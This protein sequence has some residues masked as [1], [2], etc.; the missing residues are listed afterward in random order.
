MDVDTEVEA[1]AFLIW[2]LVDNK[3]EASFEYSHIRLWRTK[4]SQAEGLLHKEACSLAGVGDGVSVVG[5][6]GDVDDGAGGVD[7]TCVR[8]SVTLPKVSPHRTQQYR[9][10]FAYR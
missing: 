8:R 5:A 1:R 6:E 10:G 7:S 9:D 2:F 4:K 3:R